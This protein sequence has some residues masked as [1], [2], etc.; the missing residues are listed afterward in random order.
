MRNADAPCPGTGAIIGQFDVQSLRPSRTAAFEAAGR[1]NPFGG[2]FGK[3]TRFGR[4]KAGVTDTNRMSS[5]TE[6]I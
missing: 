2:R 3:P 4:L 1:P 5:V 6:R